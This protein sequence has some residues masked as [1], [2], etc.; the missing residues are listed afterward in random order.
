MLGEEHAAG[1]LADLVAGAADPLQGAGHARRRLDLD[2]QVDRAHVDAELEA[3]GGDHAGQPAALE[4]VLD[5]RALLLGDRAVVG[6]GDDDLGAAPALAPGLRHH[7]R[8]VACRRS[9]SSP[10]ARAVAISLSRAVSRSAS[11]RELAKTI[12]E[13]CCSIRSATRSSTC[14][15]IEP[16]RPSSASAASRSTSYGLAVGRG[17]VLD[18]HDD[19]EVPLLLGG[20]A[21]RSRP[22]RGR[23]GT[24]PPRRAGARSRTARSAGRACRAARRGARG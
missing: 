1:H 9:G 5:Q 21:P 6:L 7:L 14:G 2:D 15:Q 8:P 22:G 13:R 3:A 11:R 4:V 20:R 24:G 10:P 19:L 12:V 16:L 18:G 23:R 17:H